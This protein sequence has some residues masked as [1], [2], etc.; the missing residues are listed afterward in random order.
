MRVCVR[1]CVY[2]YE[3]M[4]VC[5]HALVYVGAIVGEGAMKA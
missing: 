3:C 5:T 1:V 2:V 4:C